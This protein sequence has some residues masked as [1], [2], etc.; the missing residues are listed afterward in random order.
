MGLARPLVKTFDV[1]KRVYFG[2]T[3]MEAEMSLLMANQTVVREVVYNPMYPLMM[4]DT[5]GLTG[6]ADLRPVHWD[7]EYGICEHFG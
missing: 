6:E 7:R 2:N 3:S 4:H 5:S 1:K